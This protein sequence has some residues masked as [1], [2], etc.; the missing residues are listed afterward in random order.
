MLFSKL[1]K[2]TSVKKR[3]QRSEYSL[4]LAVAVVLQNGMSKKKSDKQYGN[5]RGIFQGHVK[6]QKKVKGFGK[7]LVIPHF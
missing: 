4:K 7:R 2:M 5:P 1:K 6:K 3:G